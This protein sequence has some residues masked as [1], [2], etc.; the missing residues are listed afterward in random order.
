MAKKSLE[1]RIQRLEDI[2]EIKNLMARY[3][4]LHTA[5]RHEATAELF[6]QKTPG[7]RMELSP[8]GV[9]EGTEGVKRVMVGVHKSMGVGSPGFL[10]IHTQTTSVIEVAGDG[11]TAKGVWMSPGIETRKNPATEQFIGFWMWGHYGVDF[12]KEDG[13]WKFW[14]FH[15]Y[16]LFLTPYDKSWTEP[17]TLS[18]TPLPDELRPDRPP[19]YSWWYSTTAEIQYAPAPPEPYETFDG[20]KGY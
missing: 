9:W 18:I 1:K 5:G 20:K 16:P 3:A 10:F 15:V 4:Y 6:A 2:Q 17:R 14:H 19:T 13:E 7:V 11:Q 8:L 12:V